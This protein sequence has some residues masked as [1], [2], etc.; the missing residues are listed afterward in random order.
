METPPRPAATQAEVHQE[1]EQEQEQEDPEQEEVDPESEDD[2]VGQESDQEQG[3]VLQVPAAAPLGGNNQGAVAPLAPAPVP[4]PVPAPPAPPLPAVAAAMAAAVAAAQNRRK[5]I[6]SAF[7][8]IVEKYK[9]G[10]S[11]SDWLRK[12]EVVENH[13]A[14]TFAEKM[15]YSLMFLDDS[16]R[17]ECN[18]VF[19]INRPHA[20]PGNQGEELANWNYFKECVLRI[21]NDPAAQKEA[22]DQPLK[23]LEQGGSSV[24]EYLTVFK[25]YLKRT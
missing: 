21:V 4:A 18:D 25:T 16:T 22:W 10:S 19:H 13:L 3:V 1:S 5:E 6:Q 11:I 12:I 7:T 2:Q 8:E 15:A 14:L 24:N 17:I 23:K 20:A 9:R